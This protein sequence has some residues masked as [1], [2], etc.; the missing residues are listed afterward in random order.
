MLRNRSLII[1]ML[2][3]LVSVFFVGCEDVEDTQTATSV[4]DQKETEIENKDEVEVIDSKEEVKVG[5]P[6]PI[7]GIYTKEENTMKRPFAVMFDNHKKARPQAG[8][9]QAEVVYEILAEG[10]ITR[11]MGIFL[12]NEPELIGPVRSARPYF[13]DKA[14]EFDALYVHD[15]GSPQALKDIKDLRIADVSAQSRGKETFWRKKHKPRPHNEYTSTEAIR[16]AATH[17]S[18]RSNGKYETLKFNEEDRPLNGDPLHFINL[19]YAKNYKPSFQ[20]VEKDG[21]YY[22]YINGEPHLDEVSKAHLAAKNIIVQKAATKVIDN[23]G[24]REIKLVGS[25]EGFFITTGEMK[26]ITWKK[27]SRRGITRFYYENGD[28]I[29]FNPGVTWVEVVPVNFEYATK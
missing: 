2:V 1:I 19:P 12:V 3:V 27:K 4:E 28:E 6:S 8:L 25:G 17:S 29:K 24:R 13:I 15:G 21:L 14:M 11:Y 18:Y 26:K 16:K 22:R 10:F 20:Y 5:V 23:E 9:D 7:S